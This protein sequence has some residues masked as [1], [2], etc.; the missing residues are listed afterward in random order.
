[1]KAGAG[2]E[3]PAFIADEVSVPVKA[4]AGIENTIVLPPVSTDEMRCRFP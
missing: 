1:M 3:L 2:I 4:G